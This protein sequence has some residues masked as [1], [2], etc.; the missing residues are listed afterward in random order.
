VPQLLTRANPELL[1]RA[2]AAEQLRVSERTVR[3]LGAAGKITDVR[4]T[5]HT[6]RIDAASVAR[7]IATA[8]A[9]ARNV[10]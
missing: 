6:V 1:T 9:P 2:E 7:Y 3:R 8:G 5:E 4:L 10:A